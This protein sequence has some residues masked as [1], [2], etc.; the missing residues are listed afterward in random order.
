MFARA[1]LAD[2]ETPSLVIIGGCAQLAFTP[3]RQ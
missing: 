3:E 2:N 1:I